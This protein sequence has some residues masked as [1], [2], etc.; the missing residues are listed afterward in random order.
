M[1]GNYYWSFAVIEINHGTITKSVGEIHLIR[2]QVGTLNFPIGILWI[3][4]VHGSLDQWVKWLWTSP[5]STL[6]GRVRFENSR[7]LILF[8]LIYTCLSTCILRC[9]L[10][11]NLMMGLYYLV[12]LSCIE[13][14]SVSSFLK[15]SHLET[16]LR[17]LVIP[18]VLSDRISSDQKP[19]QQTC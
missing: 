12:V 17:I 1:K 2:K 10:E 14:A 8:V 7:L 5:N 13:S 11:K 6:F 19:L 15:L 4:W 18:T 3:Q 16:P 9:E